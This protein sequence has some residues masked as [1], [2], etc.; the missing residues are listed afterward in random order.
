MAVLYGADIRGGKRATGYPGSGEQR[1]AGGPEVAA[2]RSESPA[3]TKLVYGH[4]SRCRRGGGR[5][6]P[7][8][9]YARSNGD[10]GARSRSK[11]IP[12]SIASVFKSFRSDYI[13]LRCRPT[14]RIRRVRARSAANRRHRNTGR[15]ARCGVHMSISA[16]GS[17]ETIGSRPTSQRTMVTMTRTESRERGITVDGLFSIGEHARGNFLGERG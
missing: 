17:K 6:Y 3:W 14:Q 7:W 11:A 9:H 4:R 5:R 15:S 1:M 8:R 10:S 12:P 16:A 2:S 13:G